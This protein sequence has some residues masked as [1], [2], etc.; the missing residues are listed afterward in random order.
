MAAKKRYLRK[1]QTRLRK[2]VRKNQRVLGFAAVVSFI[3]VVIAAVVVQQQMMNLNYAPLLTLIAR[4]ESHGNYNA[5]FGHGDN[6]SIK[7][8]DMTIADVLAWQQHYIESG[9]PSSAVG[10]YQ[11]LNATLANVTKQAG[12]SQDTKFTPEIQ[13]KL[14]IELLKKRGLV[15]YAENKLTP[16]Q[17]AHNLAMEWASLPSVTGNRPDASYYDGDGLNHARVSVHDVL[18]AV[19]DL[20][21]EKA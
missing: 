5:Y 13:D 10:R 2:F 12:V 20:K 6:Q 11:F 8:T 21:S 9:S 17:F 18:V 15:A 3:T 7:F 14:A 1:L 16:E 19:N 4:G